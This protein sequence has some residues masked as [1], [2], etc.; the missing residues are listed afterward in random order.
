M[1]EIFG[2]F[3]AVQDANGIDDRVYNAEQFTIPF[4]ALVTN[5]VMKSAYDQLQVV[6]TGSNMASRIKSGIAFIEGHHYLNNGIIDLTH[7]VEVLGVSRID[8]IVIRKDS[9]PEAR[10]VRAFIIKGVPGANPIAPT[11]TRN[12]NVYEISLAQV[13]I[14]GGQ[15]YILVSD[16][17]DERGKDII[18]PWA[19]SNILP[20]YNDNALAKHLVEFASTTKAGH[21]QLNDTLLS[22]STTEAATA[23]SVKMVNDKFKLPN[24]IPLPLNEGW[25]NLYSGIPIGY[26][27]DAFGVVH[28]YGHI[29][30]V[31]GNSTNIATLPV[32]Y[33][34]AKT[35]ESQVIVHSFESGYVEIGINGSIVVFSSRV[36]IDLTICI[37]ASFPTTI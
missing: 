9:R 34:P 1:A 28:L 14:V 29:Q 32:G 13:K 37:D 31:S 8:R 21:V 27:K 7:D 5:G 4:D 33:R 17:T 11:L 26:Y 30:R 20:S 22:A 24:L 16:I 25:S 35:K 19:G 36:G 6:T 2:F 10:H 12:E 15:N 23:N 18:C 3:D